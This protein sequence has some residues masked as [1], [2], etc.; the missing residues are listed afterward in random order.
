LNEY[1]TLS[2]NKDFRYKR[3]DSKNYPF[4]TKVTENTSPRDVI[5]IPV[6][7]HAFRLD[8]KRAV[9]VDGRNLPG[10]GEVLIEWVARINFANDF[11][12]LDGSERQIVCQDA[13]VDYYALYSTKPLETDPVVVMWKDRALIQCPNEISD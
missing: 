8:A 7:D 9:Y 2:P 12:E 11:Y 1:G 5:L 10:W 4:Y 6:N 13:E 3:S